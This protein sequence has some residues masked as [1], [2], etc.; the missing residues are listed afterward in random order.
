DAYSIFSL[1]VDP[2]DPTVV[3]AGTNGD[4]GA[5]GIFKSSDG[6]ATWVQKNSGV[7]DNGFG[8]VFRGFTVQPGNSA[9]V[10][11]QAELHT[12]VMGRE[13]NRTEGRVYKTNNCG[14]SWS[15]LWSGAN[16]ARHLLIDPGTPS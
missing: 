8:I 7:T 5:F 14:E 9:V 6:G 4:G 16:L 1:T 13:F 15:L 3:W 11:A 2:N 12:P 10:Y